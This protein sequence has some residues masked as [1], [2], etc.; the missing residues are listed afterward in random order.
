MKING[1]L[2]ISYRQDCVSITL[3]DEA[4]RVEFVDAE[5]SY[6][7]FA[8]GLGSLQARPL[9]VCEVRGLELVGKK[10]IWER[11]SIICPLD[12]FDKQAL[13]AWLEEN[14]QEEGWILNTYL[15]SRDSISRSAEGGTRI[16]Y[17]MTRYVEVA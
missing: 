2:S 12:T 11:R 14:A 5:I 17:S 9:T 7:E 15:G 3:V 4:S 6:E 8:R 13:A 1:Q 16:N 10:R